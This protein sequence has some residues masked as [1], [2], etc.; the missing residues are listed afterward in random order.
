MEY[1]GTPPRIYAYPLRFK[2]KEATTTRN[3][4][5]LRLIGQLRQA[6]VE[7]GG[8]H[9]DLPTFEDFG[10]GVAAHAD[11]LHNA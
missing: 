6:H 9:G 8:G 5:G 4:F 1:A 10:K 11:E 2:K 7:R 3:R